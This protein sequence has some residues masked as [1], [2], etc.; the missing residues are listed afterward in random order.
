MKLYEVTPAKLGKKRPAPKDVP[1]KEWPPALHEFV[2]RS[3]SRADHLPPNKREKF[4]TQIT[5]ILQTAANTNTI[6]LVQWDK[7]KVPVFDGGPT[8]LQLPLGPVVI[9]KDAA[10]APSFLHRLRPYQPEEPADFSPPATPADDDYS[11]SD[12]KRQRS[13]RFRTTTGTPP[14]PPPM[15]PQDGPV[16]GTCTTLEKLFLRLTSAPNP[17]L[18]RPQ[19]VLEKALDFVLNKYAEDHNYLYVINQFK[20]MRQDLTVQHIKNSF[21]IRVYEINARISLEESDLGEFNQCQTQLKVL[22]HQHR[23]TAQTQK[24]IGEEAEFII[25]RILYM[26]ITQ[27]KQELAKLRL[28]VLTKYLKFDATKHQRL[29]FNLQERLFTLL[30]Q[31]AALEYHLYFDGLKRFVQMS[32]DRNVPLAGLTATRMSHKFRVRSLAAMTA[33]YRKLGAAFIEHELGLEEGGLEKFLRKEKLEGYVQ[34]GELDCVACRQPLLSLVASPL[35]AKVDI[36]GQ[37]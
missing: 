26:L 12:R 32:K 16:R 30:S 33:A 14:P 34:A 11:S 10:I 15:E 25:Y 29:V 2:A 28:D 23:R 17:A 6:W 4:N 13:E 5:T 24:F 3:Y 36:K 9:T 27:N 37:R 1:G 8:N 21:T 7:Q 35:F 19:P 20:L 31:M 22:Y 18:V